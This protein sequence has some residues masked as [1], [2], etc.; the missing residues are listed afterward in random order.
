MSGSSNVITAGEMAAATDSA[1]PIT[2]AKF[3]PYGKLVRSLDE[4]TGELGGML[5]TLDRIQ[6]QFEAIKQTA[7]T[8]VAELGGVGVEYVLLHSSRL[9]DL[10]ESTRTLL[11]SAKATMPRKRWDDSSC[12]DDRP[13][14]NDL[15]RES[16]AGVPGSSQPGE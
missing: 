12:P 2:P 9:Y 3:I 4:V 5:E 13:D 14:D 11:E 10:H 7:D 1:S 6:A 8:G 15:A 16:A